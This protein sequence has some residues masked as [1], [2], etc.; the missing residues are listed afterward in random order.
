M[1]RLLIDRRL[2]KKAHLHLAK[3]KKIMQKLL[4][5][6]ELLI[7]IIFCNIY[8]FMYRHVRENSRL[9]Y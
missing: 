6:H 3:H 4:F 9:I 2:L 5:K 8:A 7:K 1:Q